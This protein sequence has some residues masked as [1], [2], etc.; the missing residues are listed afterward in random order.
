VASSYCTSKTRD[1]AIV[2]YRAPTC[3]DVYGLSDDVR[4]NTNAI[5][6][7][8]ESTVVRSLEARQYGAA[9]AASIIVQIMAHPFPQ[10]K[11][12]KKSNRTSALLL[13]SLWSGLYSGCRRLCDCLC[14]VATFKSIKMDLFILKLS[15]AYRKPDY[16]T[17]LIKIPNYIPG[18]PP[19]TYSS[20][21]IIIRP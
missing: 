10:A 20:Y 1:I 8:Q 3:L 12:G 7:Q 14:L 21:G 9:F 4:L 11:L 2:N 5:S 16:F 13:A 17:V 6:P 19:Y 15:A 18:V